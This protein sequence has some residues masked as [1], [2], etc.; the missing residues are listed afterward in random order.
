MSLSEKQSI[1]SDKRLAINH[2]LAPD[3]CYNP[4]ITMSVVR[5]RPPTSS[6]CKITAEASSSGEGDIVMPR[7]L[8][9]NANPKIINAQVRNLLRD[10]C[11]ANTLALARYSRFDIWRV[12]P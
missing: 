2:D 9:R 11:Q 3:N 6:A 7:L 4:R 1:T 5:E 10:F 12:G 8:A